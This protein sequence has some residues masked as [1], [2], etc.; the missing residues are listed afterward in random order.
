V[1]VVFIF[2]PQAV[3]KMT[4]GEELSK[5]INVPLLFNHMTLDILTPFLG[6]SPDTFRISQLIRCEI[7]EA[8]AINPEHDGIIL[9]FGFYFDEQSDWDITNRYIKIFENRGIEVCLVELEADLEERLRRNVTENR[10]AK[11]PSKRDFEYSE[12][13]LKSSNEK[14]RLNSNPGE[15]AHPNYFR[16]NVTNLTAE[17]SADAIIQQF[18]PQLGSPFQPKSSFQK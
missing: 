18:Y 4:I 3:G 14:H 1:R 16:L 8:I 7:L 6:W 2:G 10:L 13:E 17:E 15:F 5:K 11:K 12:W 9:T